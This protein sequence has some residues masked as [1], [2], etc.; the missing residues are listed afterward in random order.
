MDFSTAYFGKPLLTLE[1]SDIVNY[2]I[3]PKQETE[4]IEF[5][6]YPERATFDAGLQNIIRGISAF[7]NSTGGILIWG[8]PK[9][10]KQEGKSEEVFCGELC[11][12]KELKEKDSLINKISGA[13]VPL[14]IGINVQILSSHSNYVYIFEV[15]PSIHKPHQYDSRYYVRLDGQTKPAPHYLIEALIKQISYPNLNGVINFH[16]MN[17]K[18]SVLEVP[19]TIGIFNFSELQNEESVSFRLMCVGGYFSK[20]REID[21]IKRKWHYSNSGQELFY[22]DF[23]PILHFGTPNIHDELIIVEDSERNE[24]KGKLVLLLSF[25][26]KNSPAKTS[27]YTLNLNGNFPLSDTNLRIESLEENVLFSE[28]QKQLNKTSKDTLSSFTGRN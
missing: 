3:E 25:G 8:S 21:R 9:G 1:Y 11:T 18:N 12:V 23:A 24:Y 17:L 10:I 26:G 13:I 16:P 7:L 22:E 4:N 14:P 20:G 19:I 15:Q 6:S 28:R 5:K 27:Q 2:F